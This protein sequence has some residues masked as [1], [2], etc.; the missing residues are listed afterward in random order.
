MVRRLTF[1]LSVGPKRAV[2]AI[3]GSAITAR[4]TTDRFKCTHRNIPIRTLR[5]PRTVSILSSQ[6]IAQVWQQ[7]LKWTFKISQRAKR[8]CPDP[9]MLSSQIVD[10]FQLQ[11]MLRQQLFHNPAMYVS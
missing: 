10:N 3:T 11:S 7:S 6:Q 2:E 9:A 8:W 5:S 4:M 1:S